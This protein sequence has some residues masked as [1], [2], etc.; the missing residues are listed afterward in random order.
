MRRPA[1]VL[2]QQY[3]SSAAFA[4]ANIALLLLSVILQQHVIAT[5][6]Q[7]IKKVGSSGLAACRALQI[8]SGRLMSINQTLS[9]CQTVRQMTF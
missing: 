3:S 2:C 5:D 7:L 8:T 9:D 1:H 4:K 6:T